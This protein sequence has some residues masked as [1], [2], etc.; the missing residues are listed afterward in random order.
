MFLLAKIA[1]LV[2]ILFKGQEATATK[3][4]PYT[5]DHLIAWMEER[6]ASK[7]YDWRSASGCLLAQYA[8]D[9]G[10]DKNRRW[11][12]PDGGTYHGA[13]FTARDAFGLDITVG[14]GRVEPWTFGAALER[15]RALRGLA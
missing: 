4:K 2:P 8:I 10:E 6:P 1:F 14:I 3:P 12:D 11:N 15:A 13:Y 7:T 9:Q 5:L